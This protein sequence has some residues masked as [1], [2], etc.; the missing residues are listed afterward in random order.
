MP[1]NDLLRERQ[2]LF[3]K[4]HGAYLNA[5]F[6]GCVQGG[7]FI[8]LGT[9]RVERLAQAIHHL[10]KRFGQHAG[11]GQCRRWDV[12]RQSVS[13]DLARHVDQLIDVAGDPSQQ[14][15]TEQQRAQQ[16]RENHKEHADR[17]L[18]N[19]GGEI[20]ARDRHHDVPINAVDTGDAARGNI[21][22]FAG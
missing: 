21:N 8:V 15:Q 3:G 4:L 5:I 10:A 13:R 11:L 12:C 7:K 18:H 17:A 16:G 22:T 20:A 14:P 1:S 19:R 9:D 2:I 6:E